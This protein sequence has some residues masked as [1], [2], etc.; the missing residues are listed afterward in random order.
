M[1]RP[2][3]QLCWYNQTNILPTLIN[4]CKSLKRQTFNL[5]RPPQA[6]N[7]AC[8]ALARFKYGGKTS[9]INK[10]TWFGAKER[11]EL[12]H[13]KCQEIDRRK[14]KEKLDVKRMSKLNFPHIR[15]WLRISI[16]YVRCADWRLKRARRVIAVTSRV[17]STERDFNLILSFVQVTARL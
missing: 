13:S 4:E 15:R 16:I 8:E 2:E 5:V 1:S 3:L 10:K 6:L 12:I 9:P 11:V 7:I 17:D 14:W